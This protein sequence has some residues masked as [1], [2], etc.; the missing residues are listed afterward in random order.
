MNR[1]SKIS[2]LINNNELYKKVYNLYIENDIAYIDTT[3]IFNKYGYLD[4]VGMNTYESKKHKS[5]KVSIISNNRGIPL[6]INIGNGNIHDIKLL[7]D[8][9]PKNIIFNTLYA[10]KGYISKKLKETLLL[11]KIKIINIRI[12]STKN[13]HKTVIFKSLY[14]FLLKRQKYR[15]N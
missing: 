1:Y 2:L 8:T 3:T 11:R 14:T 7:I 9:L 12:L 4:T 6:G 5:N 15:Q 10:D 13:V